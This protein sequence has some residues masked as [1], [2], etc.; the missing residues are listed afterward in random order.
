MVMVLELELAAFL[1]VVVVAVALLVEKPNIWRL[2]EPDD[3]NDPPLSRTPALFPSFLWHSD[4]RV[5]IRSSSTGNR[6]G[7]AA[8]DLL[9]LQ[10][11]PFDFI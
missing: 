8:A 1:A 9:R 3:K 6:V 4:P 5:H 7:I 11:P 2:T 10:H